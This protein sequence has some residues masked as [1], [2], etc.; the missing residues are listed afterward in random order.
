VQFFHPGYQREE[1]VNHTTVNQ[2]DHCRV[3]PLHQA[4]NPLVA[5]T[6]LDAGADSLH[7]N[8]DGLMPIHTCSVDVIE[9]LLTKTDI[10]TRSRDGKTVLLNALSGGT[11][12]GSHT[13]K[14]L[15][16]E[17]AL[18]LLDLGANPNITDYNDDGILHYLCKKEEISN[19]EG[20][21]LLER[22]V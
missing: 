15:L 3:T 4:K 2:V 22:L 7:M 10:N 11:Y 21:R 8:Q 5:K 1:E 6:L 16:P 13:A 20:R 17:K 14:M 19:H 18:K 12:H 9:V